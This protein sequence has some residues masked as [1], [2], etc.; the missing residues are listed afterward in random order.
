MSKAEQAIEV[1]GGL[2]L[3]TG[4]SNILKEPLKTALSALER[5]APKSIIPNKR[6]PGLGKCPVCKTELCTDDSELHFCPTCGQALKGAN[7]DAEI[8]IYS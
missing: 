4:N 1:L 3:T 7:K 8:S 2:E 5:Q 6:I